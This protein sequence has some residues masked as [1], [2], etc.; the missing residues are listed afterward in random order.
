MAKIPISYS[1]Y[2]NWAKVP[3]GICLSIGISASI[4]GL[5]DSDLLILGLIF[6]GLFFV[7]K[8]VNKNIA[9][10]E[11]E[12]FAEGLFELDKS[13]VQMIIDD[14]TIS[15]E[16]KINRLVVLAKNGNII[17]LNILEKLLKEV[18]DNKNE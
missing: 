5:F 18:E 4:S 10:K 2:D 13:Q 7:F 9:Q 17:A 1:A 16:E 8:L 11:N 3:M 12:H 6:I 15:D 14:E